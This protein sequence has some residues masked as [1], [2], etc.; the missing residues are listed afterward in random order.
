MCNQLRISLPT[1]KNFLTFTTF[2]LWLILSTSL[3]MAGD[4][5]KTDETQK[6]KLISLTELVPTLTAGFVTF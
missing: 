6:G 1:R 5:T 4:V 2:A 3:A